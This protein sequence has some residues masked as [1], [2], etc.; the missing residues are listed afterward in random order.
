MAIQWLAAT[1]ERHPIS[2]TDKMK[3]DDCMPT[4][5]LRPFIQTYKII[6]S[7]DEL[8]NRVLPNTSLA[9]A[10]RCKGRVNYTRRTY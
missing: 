2:M 7:Q 6:E 3:I 10:F 5:L 9:I 8:V 1:V 4:E